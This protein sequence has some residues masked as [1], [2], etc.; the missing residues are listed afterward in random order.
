V[1]VNLSVALTFDIEKDCSPFL[2]TTRGIEVGLPKILRLL[3]KYDIECT[4]FI[5]GEVAE[6]FPHHVRQIAERH[7]VSSHGYIHETFDKM[8][9]PKKKRVRQSKQVLE[10]VSN[11]VVIGFRAPRFLTSKELYETL[12]EVGFKYDSSVA[13][14]TPRSLFI[15]IDFPE[16]RVQ[17]PSALLNFPKGVQVYSKMCRLT[18][19]PVLFF[20]CWEAIDTRS[21]LISAGVNSAYSSYLRPDLWVN[22]GKV[23]LEKL[24]A[25]IK[26]LLDFGLHFTTLH[27]V[28][29]SSF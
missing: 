2:S 24:E 22:T 28:V 13:Y 23:F 19:F 27:D 1:I 20:H 26:C 6:L 11:Q 29:V 16:F 3:E 5:T 9:L 17:L 8:T 12:M 15:K 21:L 4:F 14:F 7:E 10:R 18:T 25:L